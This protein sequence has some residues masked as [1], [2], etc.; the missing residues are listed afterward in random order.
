MELDRLLLVFLSSNLNFTRWRIFILVLHVGTGTETAPNSSPIL[1]FPASLGWQCSIN[2]INHNTVMDGI[3]FKCTRCQCNNIGVTPESMR[4]NECALVKCKDCRDV[5]IKCL[6]PNCT[7]SLV[8]PSTNTGYNTRRC[9]PLKRFI[10]LHINRTHKK[11]EKILADTP[12]ATQDAKRRKTLS[13]HSD[14]ILFDQQWGGHFD[15]REFDKSEMDCT[16]KMSNASDQSVDCTME[17]SD[18]DESVSDSSTSKSTDE[19]SI[20]GNR[21]G[22]DDVDY[23]LSEEENEKQI[24]FDELI[25]DQLNFESL[26]VCVDECNFEEGKSEDSMLG[27]GDFGI[28][29]FRPLENQKEG[30]KRR[31]LC[32]SQLYMYQKY[33]MK[34]KDKSNGAGGFQGLTKR[35][36]SEL[37]N[38]LNGTVTFQEAD[39]M[40]ELTKLCIQLPKEKQIGVMNYQQKS[41]ACL[42]YNKV[43]ISDCGIKIPKSYPDIRRMITE[44]PYSILRNFPTGNV[45]R[46]GGHSCISLKEIFLL[47]AGHHGGFSFSYD[48]RTKRYN[49]D[50]LNGTKAVQTLRSDVIDTLKESGKSDEEIKETNI[51]YFYFWS[52]SFLRCFVKQKNNSVW[53]L[54][55]TISPPLDKISTGKFTHVL[56]IGKSSEDHS[57]VFTHFHRE[58][59]ELMNG[60]NCYYGDENAMRPTALAC[61]FNSADRPENASLANTRQEGHFGKV[62][63]YSANPG[64]KFAACPKCYK[65]IAKNAVEETYELLDCSRCLG[66]SISENDSPRMYPKAPAGYPK[67][68]AHSECYKIPEEDRNILKNLDIP[69]SRMPGLTHLGPMK[70]TSLALRSV[71]TYAYH[72]F[73]LRIWTKSVAEQYLRTCNINDKRICIVMEKADNDGKRKSISEPDTYLP[74]I[75]STDEK[76]DMFQRFKLPDLPLHAIAHGIIDNVMEATQKIFAHWKKYTEYTE[77]ANLT[78]LDVA[79]F[80]LSWC[81]LKSL[82]KASWIGEHEMAYMRLMLYLLGRYFVSRNFSN[83]VSLHVMNMKRLINALQSFVSLVMSKKTPCRN[84]VQT[85]VKLLMSTAHQLQTEYGSLKKKAVNDDST[86]KNSNSDILDDLSRDDV[87]SLLNQLSDSVEEKKTTNDLRKDLDRLCTVQR[88]KLKMEELNMKTCSANCRKN[89]YQILLFGRLLGRDLSYLN[90]NKQ[91]NYENTDDQETKV[92][93]FMWSKGAWISLCTNLAGQ[94]EYLGYLTLIW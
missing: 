12:L 14:E 25:Q 67:M 10:T 7:S 49:E 81:K 26:A 17:M 58:A 15:F 42:G 91:S 45:F 80:R 61:L 38:D 34:A 72:A 76:H 52:D 24:V 47:A 59:R 87:I 32:C 51:G 41:Q 30:R 20:G 27:F 94:I 73:R 18:A 13:S 44:G 88:M 83:E 37:M 3:S 16:L 86:K 40:F 66:W 85:L 21:P 31:S 75:W 71:C 56:A 36:M 63:G 92:D 78:I 64:R 6:Y 11:K 65:T 55:V 84:R 54:T 23:F 35:T 43:P 53:I 29:D 69:L 50:G 70:L 68:N 82:P 89:N 5:F 62:R 33:K 79:T 22:D 1:P 57:D 74:E 60:F 48:G 9:D 93:E 2:L 90:I 46:I 19:D 8:H 28:Y 39:A 77:N 4:D